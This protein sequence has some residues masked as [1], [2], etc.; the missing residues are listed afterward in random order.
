MGCPLFLPLPLFLRDTDI[1]RLLTP[2]LVLVPVLVLIL[3]LVLVVV[4]RMVM[5]EVRVVWVVVVVK[6]LSRALS[7]DRLWA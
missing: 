7:Q 5:V 2:P 3:V 4:V 1:N 6:V